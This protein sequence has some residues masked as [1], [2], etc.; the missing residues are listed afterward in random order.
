MFRMRPFVRATPPP[1]AG[2]PAAA[3]SEVL[4]GEHRGDVFVERY[5]EWREACDALDSAYREWVASRRSARSIAFATYRAAL[6]REEKAA[7][8]YR[9][10]AAELADPTRE[11]SSACGAT[12]PPR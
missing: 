11:P 10:V 6:D 1:A 4:Q 5:V 12:A 7:F 2:V 8:E 3:S 9:L